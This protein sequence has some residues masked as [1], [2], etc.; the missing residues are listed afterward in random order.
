MS[1]I[2][3]C[4]LSKRIFGDL[5]PSFV[6]HVIVPRDDSVGRVESREHLV[7]A[8]LDGGHFLVG[9]DTAL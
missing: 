1:K 4:H 2:I 6:S 7:V 3:L 5:E 9:H 8:E